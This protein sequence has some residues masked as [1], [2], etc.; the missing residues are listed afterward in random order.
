[1]SRNLRIDGE[2]DQEFAARANRA[3]QYAKILLDAALAN[4]CI[5]A[6]I[7]DS[8]LPHSEESEQRNPTVRIDFEQAFAVAG[9]G[10]GINATRNKSW[11]DG[12]YILPLEPDDP[13]DPFHIIYVFKEGSLYNR[14]FEQRRRMKELLGRH[15]RSLVEAA[16]YKRT[17]KAMFLQQLTEEQAGD[18]RRI[19]GIE[20]GV[21]W[22]AC[23]GKVF[24]DLPP[25]MVQLELPFQNED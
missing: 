18:I 13:V 14:R 7:A 4:K 10:E 8:A 5:R 23:R 24:L 17:T 21:F 19:F 20:P 6:F 22:R 12:P 9:I 3:A 15:H 2:S 25:R 16:K 1:M 11:G